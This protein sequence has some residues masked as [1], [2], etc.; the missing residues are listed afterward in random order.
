M[1]ELAARYQ[2]KN[3]HG[4]SDLIKVKD[5]NQFKYKKNFISFNVNNFDVQEKGTLQ[6]I[7][8]SKSGVKVDIFDRD[9]KEDDD[10]GELL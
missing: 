8:D 4:H 5:G 2:G 6:D 3:A 9:Y 7:V 10:N 1:I